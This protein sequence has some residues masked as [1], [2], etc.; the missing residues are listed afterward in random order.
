MGFIICEP[1]DKNARDVKV[2][3]FT[4]IFELLNVTDD[5]ILQKIRAKIEEIVKKSSLNNK[6]QSLS[7]T[8]LQAS[9]GSLDFETEGA[10]LDIIIHKDNLKSDLTSST[11]GT[12]INLN[13]ESTLHLEDTK[14]SNIPEVKSQENKQFKEEIFCSFSYINNLESSL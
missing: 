6:D 8:P 10:P 9:S 4:H 13:V 3:N 12:H 11:D 5:D 14:T 2:S 1:S 7:S